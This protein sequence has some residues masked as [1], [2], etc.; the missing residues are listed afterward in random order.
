MDASQ[1]SALQDLCLKMYT[2]D[3]VARA[4]A[5]QTLSPFQTQLDCVPQ[6]YHIVEHATSPYAI[7]FAASSL[8]KLL[9]HHWNT[10]HANQKIE[11]KNI[12]LRVL[13]NRGLQLENYSLVAVVQVIARITKLGWSDEGP[14]REII[15]EASNFLQM[16]PGHLSIGLNIYSQII[17]E[18]NTQ[19]SN[20]TLTQH[21]K[22]AISFRDSGLLKIFQVAL[23][24]IKQLGYLMQAAPQYA[25]KVAEQSMTL[26]VQCTGYDFIGATVDETSDD[27]VGT[28]QIPSGWRNIFEDPANMKLFFDIYS[29]AQPP[30]SSQAM[31]CLVQF[32]S[33]RRSLFMG[34]KE[35]TRFLQQLLQGMTE[36]LRSSVGLNH[37]QNY[38]EFCR[39]LARIKSNYQIVE[40]VAAEGYQE[41][42]SLVHGFTLSSLQAYQWAPNS[43][44]YLLGLWSK[45]VASLPYLRSEIPSGIDKYAPE[46]VQAYVQSR[47]DLVERAV[48]A[49]E[50]EEL[51][52]DEEA[53]AEQLEALPNLSRCQYPKSTAYIL[54]LMDP[55]MTQY[56]EYYLMPAKNQLS[57][58]MQ[59]QALVLESKL[60]WLVY[61]L[62]CLVAGR[63]SSG[64]S[65]END[66]ID[67]EVVWR[68]FQL[69]QW[70]DARLA[71]LGPSS[72]NVRL[73][74][75]IIS[76]LNHFRKVYIGEQTIT[77]SK[78]YQRLAERIP[79]IDLMSILDMFVEK[80]GT[81]LK[82]WVGHDE[83]IQK[84]LTLFHDLSA[85]Y[86]SGKNLTKL[87]KIDY[88]FANHASEFSAFLNAYVAGR[89]R[90][91]FYTTISRLLFLGESFHRFDEFMAP[92]KQT[93]DYLLSQ[94]SAA[95]F[96]TELVRNMVTGL[97]RDLH[98]ICIA[99]NQRKTY[100]LLFEWLYP[101]YMPIFTRTAEAWFDAPKVTT[102]LLKFLSDFVYNKSQR[103]V[104]DSSSPNGI[105][106]FR[107]IS[108][109]L[110][111]YGTPVLSKN[112]AQ[113]PY[114]EKYKGFSICMTILARTLVGNYVNFGVFGLYGDNCLDRALDISVR[115]I[116]CIP[117]S[118]LMKFPKVSKSFFTVLE[119][120]FQNHA[121]FMLSLDS[122]SFSR[123]VEIIKDGI[124]CPDVTTCS[125][126]CNAL[127]AIVS[128][129]I[130]HFKD[131]ATTQ[132]MHAHIQAN[133]T[134]LTS[135]LHMIFG[136]VIYEDS[137][138]Q[139]NLS[140]PLF[141]LI[142]M[143]EQVTCMP[144]SLYMLYLEPAWGL[145]PDSSVCYGVF[146][147]NN[148][149][150]FP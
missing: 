87:P 41:W 83:I 113:D 21:R 36:I 44:Y 16:T 46:V 25:D 84:T 150:L 149:L 64:L 3:N 131:V 73:E 97:F 86:G 61:I 53:F 12:I 112:I 115:M 90:T 108:N 126:A 144:T 148:I 17:T 19:L 99:C 50:S 79:N 40:L 5:E 39:L 117:A 70:M 130:Q 33:V 18:I 106:L 51:F 116:L 7:H 15:D 129:P 140:R 4:Q 69:R 102:A 127:D 120:M 137:A 52:D 37:P 9:T 133:P 114:E 11:I 93:C 81:N 43:K 72:G 32:A 82:L 98:G 145:I 103:L 20:R 107:E 28:L 34:E 141:S 29:S 142:L 110:V 96:R 76:F 67:G 60:S 118:D 26:F 6:C 95:A 2:G 77:N 27:L 42:I 124:K 59:A 57:E 38:H 138:N 109:V 13:A 14:F 92:M 30:R 139:W 135:F 100:L 10:I 94:N 45:L 66:L 63:L 101:T 132:K 74:L 128:Y 105:L 111:C 125:L 24:S 47:L 88:L 80:I 91:M 143:H 78:M 31:E 68:V 121:P 146:C 71:N 55:L 1:L 134:I 136:M 35:R 122:F 89:N 147:I 65:E 56:S 22:T 8:S 58:Q 48:A 104:F 75:S 54:G 85:G 49:G 123:L 62:G 23:S 119:T